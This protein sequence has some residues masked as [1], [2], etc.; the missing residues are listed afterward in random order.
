M[1]QTYAYNL[2]FRQFMEADTDIKSNG[3]LDP[4]SPQAAGRF[5]RMLR[6]LAGLGHYA[7]KPE[8]LAK[9]PREWITTSVA[10]AATRIKQ[11][12]Q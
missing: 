2:N 7:N 9:L 3:R 10:A 1:S 4:K 11:R 8:V 5:G 6:L 12:K